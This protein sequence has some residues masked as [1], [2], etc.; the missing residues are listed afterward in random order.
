MKQIIRGWKEGELIQELR[1][2]SGTILKQGQTVRYKKF[3]SHPDKDGY[4]FSKHEFHYT[5][6]ENSNLIRCTRLLIKGE[7]LID[8]RK[9]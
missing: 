7:P 4:M 5:D 8:L 6:I 2:V 3:K 9:V 1:S